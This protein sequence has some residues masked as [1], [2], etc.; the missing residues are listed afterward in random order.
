ME[1]RI[2]VGYD[3]ARYGAP[4]QAWTQSGFV[5]PLM[6]VEDRY[7]FDPASG[8]Y[9]VDR[10]LDDLE[11]R[12]GGIDD[13][14]VWPTY[15]NLGIDNRNQL[16][17]ILAM[18]G[19]VAG[20]KRMVSDFHRR[21][22]K[23]LFPINMWDEGTRDPGKPWPEAVAALMKEVGADGVFG[24]TQDGVPLAFPLAAE[25]TGHAMAFQTELWP[26]DEDVA[27]NLS[28]WWQEAPSVYEQ[29]AP[30]IDRYKWIEPR[31]IPVIAERWSR[32][33]TDVLQTAFFNGIGVESWENIFGFWNGLTERDAES[34]RRV[35]AMERGLAPFLVSADWEPFYPML[36]FGVFASRWP[37][38]DEASGPSSTATNIRWKDGRWPCH[39]EPARI[40]SISI[41][42]LNFRGSARAPIWFSPSP[43]KAAALARCWR[44]VARLMPP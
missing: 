43:W 40:I 41:A 5:Q 26:N 22:V 33:K 24:D 2:Y 19:G 7:F 17:M 25:R 15:P 35:A 38:Q 14:I 29:F 13:V 37:L 8:K 4:A 21:G 36:N 44:S 30:A 34:L 32:D 18:P 39:S 28:S 6:M 27:W 12:Y 20:V 16:D 3:G 42:G 1:R 10:Y 11:R 9:T 23:V 31:H